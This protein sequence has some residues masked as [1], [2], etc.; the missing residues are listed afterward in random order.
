MWKNWFGRNDCSVKKC[1]QWQPDTNHLWKANNSAHGTEVVASTYLLCLTAC[2]LHLLSLKLIVR[3]L[4][5]NTC[6]DKLKFS[7]YLVSELDECIIILYKYY[8]FINHKYRIFGMYKKKL[9]RK[10]SNPI[11]WIILAAN[12]LDDTIMKDRNW[13]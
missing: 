8:I 3:V 11:F 12:M 7:R 1:W 5:I 9:W 6:S 13:L 2:L 4:S 10:S